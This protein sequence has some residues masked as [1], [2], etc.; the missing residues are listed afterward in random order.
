MKIVKR[1]VS[2]M[3]TPLH[4]SLI[5]ASG[6]HK[7]RFLKELYTI[8]LTEG[9]PKV[10]AYLLNE[11]GLL[12]KELAKLCGVEPATMTVLLRRMEAQGL[13]R[14]EAVRACGGKRAFGIYLTDAGRTA[15]EKALEIIDQLEEQSYKGFTAEERDLLSTLLERIVKNIQSMEE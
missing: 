1:R 11:E 4:V 9:Q 2:A 5:S 15:G 14:K 3:R 12:Q 10:L 8:G 6:A 7:K 13:I